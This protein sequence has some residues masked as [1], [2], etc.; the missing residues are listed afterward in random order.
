MK[1]VEH[2]THEPLAMLWQPTHFYNF[3][4]LMAENLP[5][6]HEH[7]C[8]FFGHCTHDTPLMPATKTTEA[9]AEG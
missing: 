1:D 8:R 5:I 4:H 9:A 7:Q 2:W 3:Y 6:I